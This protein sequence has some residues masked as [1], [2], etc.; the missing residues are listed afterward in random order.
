MG[1]EHSG[2]ME[3]IELVVPIWNKHL[4]KVVKEETTGKVISNNLKLV[5]FELISR[6]LDNPIKTEMIDKREV[7]E[8]LLL[9][10]QNVYPLE[11]MK[12]AL[13]TNGVYLEESSIDFLYI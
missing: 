7:I 9:D 2:R 6:A 13:E 11:S 12:K 3:D 1:K 4:K 8:K 10:T 5:S